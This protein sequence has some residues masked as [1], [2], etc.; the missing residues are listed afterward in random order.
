MQP[1]VGV[2]GCKLLSLGFRRGGEEI[3]ARTD[4]YALGVIWYQ[5]VT[6]HLGLVT[7]PEG[8]AHA[9]VPFAETCDRPHETR[10][11]VG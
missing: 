5:L 7:R 2:L 6:G 4:V 8:F 3:D 9:V 11:R 1:V 10:R